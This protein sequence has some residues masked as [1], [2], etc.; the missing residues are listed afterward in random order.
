MIGSKVIEVEYFYFED[1][2]VC[3]HTH[4][5]YGETGYNFYIQIKI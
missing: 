4:V 2:V 3:T 1:S 5:C